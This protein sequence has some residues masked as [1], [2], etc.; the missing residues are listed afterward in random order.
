MLQDSSDEDYEGGEGVGGVGG[1]EAFKEMMKRRSSTKEVK[2]EEKKNL[3]DATTAAH[4]AATTA[5]HIAATAAGKAD[6]NKK[7]KEEV[8]SLEE[9]K[10]EEEEKTNLQLYAFVAR[11]IA[12]P[13]G[14][15]YKHDTT[16]RPPK[17]SLFQLEMAR[18]RFKAF[19]AGHNKIPSDEAFNSAVANFYHSVLLSGEV[20]KVVEGAGWSVCDFSD[21]FNKCIQEQI[22]ALPDFKNLSKQTLH[23]AWMERFELI[24]RGETEKRM[25][26]IYSCPAVED[27]KLGREQLFE[28]FQKVL[29]VRRRQHQILHNLMQV[30]AELN[31]QLDSKRQLWLLLNSG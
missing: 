25:L 20:T 30:C 9:K 17:I 14:A 12:Y 22:W 24:F 3:K 4:I 28:M 18:D 5:A 1:V 8:D 29:K 15:T 21:V 11:C 2:Q 7:K 26:P 19:L 27:A 16:H 23:D 10:R 31:Y 6:A 13:F